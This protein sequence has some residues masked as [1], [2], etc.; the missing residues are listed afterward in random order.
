MLQRVAR[1]LVVL[2]ALVTLALVVVWVVTN[3]EFGRERVRRFALDA[4]SKSTHGI[5]KLGTIRGDLLTGA[6]IAGISITDSAG[7]PFLKAD[8]LSGRYT[9]GN[10][11]R[12]RIAISDLVIYR[13]D[14]VIEKLP[15][16]RDW[17]YRRLWPASKPTPGDTI[18]G[19]GSWIRFDNARIVEGH[20]TVRSPWSPRAGITARA[21]DSLVN[22]A[23]TG[24]SRLMVVQVPGGFVKVIE[25]RQ[26]TGRF[27]LV[28][29]ADPSTD[30]PP[31][32]RRRA[33][34]A[35]AAIPPA[36]G[37]ADRGV[38]RFRF[39]D[40]SLWWKGV[41]VDMPGSKMRG[42]GVYVIENGDMRLAST[43]QP[44][45]FDDFRWLYPHMP[46]DGGGTASM[47][48]QWRGATQDYVMRSADVRTGGARI[49]GDFGVTMTDTIVFHDADLRF[50]GLTTRLIKEIAPAIDPPREGVLVGRAK[51]DGTPKRLDLDAD[52]TFASY[53]RGT[54]RSDRRRRARHVGHADRGERARS[55]RADGADADRHREAAVPH[56]ADRRHADGNGDDSTARAIVSSSCPESTSC[57]RTDPTARA[58]SAASPCTPPADRRWTWT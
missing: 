30:D 4:L 33:A 45:A 16:E 25:L 55:A 3:T 22:E 58:R 6:T 27:P 8:S 50:T 20:L 15:G 34:H 38:G 54:S 26:L 56:P 32:R 11:L 21:R 51:F 46:K 12:K 49:L 44:A 13:P 10:L 1:L 18:P 39:T 40:D 41:R 28:Q 35:G 5:V 43:A 24:K 42:D 47:L 9:L 7:R 19:F 37:A 17:N 48:I 57:I 14:I 31:A 2:L 29:L 23:L 36:R 53:D 52:V